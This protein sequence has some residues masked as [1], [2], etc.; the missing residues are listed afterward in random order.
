MKK[1]FM[2]FL[3]TVTFV[4]PYSNAQN[5]PVNYD[6]SKVPEYILPDPLT[7][8][9]GTKITTA[10]NWMNKRRPEILEIFKNE[11]YGV[12][13]DANIAKLHYAERQVDENAL[14][15]KA[16]RKE[17]TLY[18]NWPETEPKVEILTY[19]PKEGNGPF[20]AFLGLNFLGNH[21]VSTEPGILISDISYGTRMNL[22]EDQETLRGK[23]WERW[24]PEMVVGHGYA[25]VT[26]YYEEIAPD[27]ASDEEFGVIPLINGYMK[28]AGLPDEVAPGRISVWAWGLSRILDTMET[29]PEID[30]KRV[31][32]IGHSRLGKT[33]L[34]AGA[35]DP[36]FALV[37]SNNSGC[38]G[39][40]LYR[41]EFGETLDRMNVVFPYWFCK[42]MGK[43][44]G[45]INTL[46]FDQHELIA[47]IA[48]RPVYVAS[49]EEDQWADP[50]GEF[51]SCLNADPVYRLFNTDGIA[52]VTKWPAVNNPVGGIIHYHVRTGIH[53]VTAYDWEQ[54]L[55]FADKYMK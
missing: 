7:A 38:G 35:N 16:I 23:Q 13:P 11:L 40:A 29:M 1:V 18:F 53:N 54:Y 30:A 14:E 32:V 48:P 2:L 25:L 3:L 28:S 49:A 37:I 19:L 52:G 22:K 55:L 51:L 8:N 10:E 12:M 27:K 20:P 50:R 43:Y 41:R 31:A 36:R 21:T 34:W 26:A 15:G 45:K 17:G 6:E 44:V 42:N 5:P 4:V 9:D 33:A 24:Q 39:A 47:L 46:P